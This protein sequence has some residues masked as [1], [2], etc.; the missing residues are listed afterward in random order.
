MPNNAAPTASSDHA[1][2]GLFVGACELKRAK[3]SIQ[4]EGLHQKHEVLIE[5]YDVDRDTTILRGSGLTL[6]EALQK[7]LQPICPSLQSIEF[8]RTVRA[9]MTSQWIAKATGLIKG[10]ERCGIGKF[11]SRFHSWVQRWLP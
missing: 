6:D 9:D 10:A 7:T 5:L 11:I 1:L 8:E 4:G 3:Y 2:H